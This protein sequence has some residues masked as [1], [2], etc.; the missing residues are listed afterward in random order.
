M[1]NRPSCL[2][3]PLLNTRYERPTLT[4]PKR[5]FGGHRNQNLTTKTIRRGWKQSDDSKWKFTPLFNDPSI[6]IRHES[7]NG[8]RSCRK[9][10][11]ERTYSEVAGSSTLKSPIAKS[12][13]V[14]FHHPYS[15]PLFLSNTTPSFFTVFPRL[16]NLAHLF[17]GGR[18]GRLGQIQYP[19]EP[20]CEEAAVVE[21]ALLGPAADVLHRLLRRTVPVELQHALRRLGARPLLQRLCVF[22]ADCKF[23]VLDSY[24][25]LILCSQSQTLCPYSFLC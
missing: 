12:G 23:T 8:V 11:L 20:N 5:P 21:V 24:F 17:E 13:C 25:S 15:L 2:E 18:I 19:E 7:R 14:Y 6:G 4:N 10:N 1:S 3:K 9:N 16:E 22:P